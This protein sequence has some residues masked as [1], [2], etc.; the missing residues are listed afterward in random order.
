MLAGSADD[1]GYISLKEFLTNEKVSLT[2]KSF[3]MAEVVAYFVEVLAADN[4]PAK[5][6]KSLIES[7][8]Q[9]FKGEH[10]Q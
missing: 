5:D 1:N 4:Q 3:T 10:V 6:F 7:S 8:Y 2:L 9:L